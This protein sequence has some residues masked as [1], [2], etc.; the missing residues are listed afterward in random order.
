MKSISKILA[1]KQSRQ[2][3]AA[4]LRASSNTPTSGFASVDNSTGASLASSEILP[5]LDSC[6]D[7]LDADEGDFKLQIRAVEQVLCSKASRYSNARLPEGVGD[8]WATNHRVLDQVLVAVECAVSVYDDDF[9]YMNADSFS[10]KTTRLI[11]PS[12]SGVVKAT[13]FIEVSDDTG[14]NPD[15][16]ALVVA[17][18]GTRMHVIVDWLVNFN[19]ELRDTVDF[20]DLKSLVGG[21]PEFDLKVHSG[22]LHGARAL[23]ADVEIEILKCLESTNIRHVIF[24]GHSA[25]GAVA[26]LAYLQALGAA[27][28]KYPGMRFSLI[29][30]GAPPISTPSLAPILDAF[31]MRQ[32]TSG[33]AL[34]IV[35]EDDLVARADRS[36]IMSLLKLYDITK[37]SSNLHASEIPWVFPEPDVH[38]IGDIVVLREDHEDGP[39]SKV[40]AFRLT[41]GKFE[42]L[43]FCDRMMHQKEM[44]RKLL[45]QLRSRYDPN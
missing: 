45:W 8:I 4:S 26:S 31:N 35:N 16:P 3:A 11:S 41:A 23:Q 27:A 28:I 39:A 30:F 32:G 21:L 33:M 37:T 25:G 34:A 22:F 14:Q 44:Y 20:L 42:Q 1:G 5:Y 29:T 10:Y 6:F 24:T 13:K 43:I 2:V 36:Y 12:P 17:V 38:T 9:P 40:E 18:R 7:D 15:F 19:H